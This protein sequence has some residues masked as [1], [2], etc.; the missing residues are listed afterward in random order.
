MVV[1]IQQRTVRAYLLTFTVQR[2]LI[3]G[4]IWNTSLFESIPIVTILAITNTDSI[5][6]SLTLFA[7]INAFAFGKSSTLF[8]DFDALLCLSAPF[9]ISLAFTDAFFFEVI[10]R[11]LADG[12]ALFSLLVPLFSKLATV[13]ALFVLPSLVGGATLDAGLAVPFLVIFGAPV[14]AFA[15]APGLV[16]LAQVNAFTVFPLGPWGLAFVLAL[17]AGPYLECWANFGAFTSGLV[18]T[19]IFGAFN[20]FAGTNILIAGVPGWTKSVGT[21]FDGSPGIIHLNT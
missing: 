14:V 19:L 4:T 7:V 20:F 9:R 5:F 3:L 12:V 8:A 11:F 13:N 10:F 17:F 1:F 15:I 6:P 18:E 2:N 16:G 21:L